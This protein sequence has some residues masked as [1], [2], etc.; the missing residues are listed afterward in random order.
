MLINRGCPRLKFEKI[1]LC[2]CFESVLLAASNCW[3]LQLLR[4]KPNDAMQ[5]KRKSC[6]GWP[7]KLQRS[8]LQLGSRCI[9]FWK[10]IHTA[11]TLRRFH[12]SWIKHMGWTQEATK[13]KDC[14]I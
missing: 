1:T 14:L 13:P 6:A 5:L 9:Y 12:N 10:G 8:G 4:T 3:L 11:I 7:A 2:F